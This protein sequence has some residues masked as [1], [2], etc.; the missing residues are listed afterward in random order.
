[1]LLPI[2]A[3]APVLVQEG[4]AIRPIVEYQSFW[5]AHT[6]TPLEEDADDHVHP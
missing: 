6:Q 4:P 5:E 2:S 1:M 3:A